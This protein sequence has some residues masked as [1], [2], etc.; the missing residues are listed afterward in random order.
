MEESFDIQTS[1]SGKISTE[2]IAF[3]DVKSVKKRGM[4]KSIKGLIIGG[5]IIG[6]LVAMAVTHQQ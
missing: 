2:K 1:Q 4:S 6:F 5:A 3:A